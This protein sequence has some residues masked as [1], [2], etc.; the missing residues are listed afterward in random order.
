MLRLGF[1]LPPVVKFLATR[2]VETGL[3]QIMVE[4]TM[5]ITI[6]DSCTGRR[7]QQP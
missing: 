5:F 2:L 7:W 6:F 3:S 4:T 1:C